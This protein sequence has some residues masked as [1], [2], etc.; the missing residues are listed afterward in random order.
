MSDVWMATHVLGNNGYL[1]TKV[2]EPQFANINSITASVQA[3]IPSVTYPSMLIF[4][5]YSTMR[6]R[7]MAS[8]DLPA[9]VRPTTP[10]F[11]PPLIDNE[12]P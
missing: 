6:N 9:P 2:M 4:P 11:S 5:W 12:I 8:D 3:V 1:H 10:T 7:A